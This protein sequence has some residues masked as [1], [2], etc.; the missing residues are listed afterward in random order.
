MQL[1]VMY[2]SREVFL[3]MIRD[4]AYHEGLPDRITG[5]D[6]TVFVPTKIALGEA[7]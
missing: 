2:P 7:L 1:L 4:P 6:N 5:L 3:G